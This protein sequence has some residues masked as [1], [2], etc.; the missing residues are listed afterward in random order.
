MLFK[1][2]SGNKQKGTAYPHHH[3]KFDI[4]EDALS[5]GVKMFLQT[6]MQLQKKEEVRL[7]KVGLFLHFEKG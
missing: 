3:P 4:D 5:I 2:G 7:L 1:V 6:A